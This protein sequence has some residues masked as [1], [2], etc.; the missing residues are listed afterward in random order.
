ME[1]DFDQHLVQQ[2][3]NPEAVEING[4]SVRVVDIKP[5]FMKTEVVTVFVPGFSAVAWSL[6]DAILSIAQEGR[7]VVSFYAVH[8]VPT[9]RTIGGLSEGQM[10]KYEVLEAVVNLKDLNEIN[11]VANSEA[12]IYSGVFANI[13]SKKVSSVVMVAPAGFM[14]KD[15]IL[16]VL[17]RF[18]KDAVNDR[19]LVKAGLPEGFSPAVF[20]VSFESGAKAISSD[21]L[22]SFKEIQGIS[23]F[24]LAPIV[25]E[26][27]SKGVKF[28]IIHPQDDRLF[29]LERLKQNLPEL[30]S[31]E[32]FW[33]AHNA[34][35]G[36]K[37]YGTLAEKA[38]S[39]LEQ[40]SLIDKVGKR[41]RMEIDTV[42]N[43]EV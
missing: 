3:D 32:V 43:A 20:P 18:C 26:A 2:F 30:D 28:A 25:T 12:A 38:L 31:V 29:P 22:A 17:F 10:R 33:G 9:K 11:I 8:G 34:I 7:R 36:Y 23:K 19:R 27:R 35:Y 4:C 14:G 6:K 37:P 41:D 24:N 42:I 39:R 5:K 1:K 13:Y 16:S 21:L 40:K 15:N